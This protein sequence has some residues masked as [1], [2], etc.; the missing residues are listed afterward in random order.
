MYGEGSY[1]L[2]EAI[3]IVYILNQVKDKKKKGLF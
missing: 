2:P 1:Q 3:I